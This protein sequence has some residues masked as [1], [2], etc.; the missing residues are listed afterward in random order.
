MAGNTE[1]NPIPDAELAELR[2][3][4]AAAIF[5]YGVRADDSAWYSIGDPTTGPHIQGDI[6]ADEETL[7]RLAAVWNAF[8]SILAR[9]EAAEREREEARKEVDLVRNVSAKWLAENN[10][11][12]RR[13]GAADE[14][15]AIAASVRAERPN[16]QFVPLLVLD[17]WAQKLREGGE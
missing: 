4:H 12:Q 7:A 8:P 6:Y 17:F 1:T 13:E 3:L 5:R 11:Q 15:K 16:E 10:A 2:R 14:L 9:L